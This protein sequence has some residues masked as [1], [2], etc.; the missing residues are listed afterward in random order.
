VKIRKKLLV[1]AIGV[2]FLLVLSSSMP[3][4]GEWSLKLTAQAEIKLDELKDLPAVEAQRHDSTY[5]GVLLRDF[6]T[7]VG[8]D[9]E[10]VEYVELVASDGYRVRYEAE[11]VKSS[12]VVLAYEKDG[13]PLPKREGK[14]RAIVVGGRSA[15]QIKFVERIEVK[16]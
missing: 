13:S 12:K 10:K 9:V 15:M 4:S 6:L 3:C 16:I 14:V 7:Y 11:L 1:F 8:I 5:K 2:F